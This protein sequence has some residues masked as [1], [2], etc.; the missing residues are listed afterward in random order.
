MKDAKDE[1]DLI[2]LICELLLIELGL[3]DWIILALDYNTRYV[4]ELR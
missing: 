3:L 2:I 4:A 1:R